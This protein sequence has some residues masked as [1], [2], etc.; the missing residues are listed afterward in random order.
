MRNTPATPTWFAS[1]PPRKGPTKNP[2]MAAE[3]AYPWMP[4]PWP[5]GARRLI[6]AYSAGCTPATPIPS[7]ARA[8]SIAGIVRA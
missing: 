4:P 7:S 8:P 3:D 5:A 6:I 2:K 1:Q